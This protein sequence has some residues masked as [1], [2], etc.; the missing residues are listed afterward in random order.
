MTIYVSIILFLLP[1]KII[2][3]YFDS[4]NIIRNM[5]TAGII[6]SLIFAPAFII[7]PLSAILIEKG[8]NYAVISVFTSTLMLVGVLTSPIEK[9]YF[10]VKFTVVRNFTGLII[11]IIISVVTGVF[12]REFF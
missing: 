2:I 1:D 9:K 10:G 12:Y 3:E 11:S 6:G 5:I 8:V 4:P 7:F